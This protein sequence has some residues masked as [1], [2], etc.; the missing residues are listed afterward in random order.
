M[1][2]LI[3]KYK[4][5]VKIEVPGEMS[6]QTASLRLKYIDVSNNNGTGLEG[7]PIPGFKPFLH[8][9]DDNTKRIVI[10]H[11]KKSDEKKVRTCCSRYLLEEHEKMGKIAQSL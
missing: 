5:E 7:K 2:P 6:V 8:Y 1:K 11:T 3:D 4:H 9:G 10:V